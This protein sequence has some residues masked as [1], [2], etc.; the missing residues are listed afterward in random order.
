MY[1]TKLQKLFYTPR[2]IIHDEDGEQILSA[3][4]VFLYSH[5]SARLYM[6]ANHATA[7]NLQFL[8]P[9]AATSGNGVLLRKSIVGKLFGSR[10]LDIKICWRPSTSYGVGQ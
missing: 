2:S 4:D 10:D 8:F 1:H 3:D 9:E 7:K 6:A 5:D